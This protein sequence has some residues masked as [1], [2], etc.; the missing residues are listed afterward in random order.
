MMQPFATLLVAS[1][2]AASALAVPLANTSDVVPESLCG[3][4]VGE[5]GSSIHRLQVMSDSNESLY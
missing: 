4:E 1:S 5:G 2:L 3:P